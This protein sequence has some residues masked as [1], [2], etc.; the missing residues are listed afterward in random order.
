MHAVYS[1]VANT[2]PQLCSLLLLNNSSYT[3]EP[4]GG[5]EYLHFPPVQFPSPSFCWDQNFL[6]FS[7]SRCSPLKERTQHYSRGRSHTVGIKFSLQSFPQGEGE[8]PDT[9]PFSLFP[10][11]RK[12]LDASPASFPPPFEK[13]LDTSSLS[14]LYFLPLYTFPLIFPPP[15]RG[16]QFTLFPCSIPTPPTVKEEASVANWGDIFS[17]FQRPIEN[18]YNPLKS[19]QNI[20]AIYLLAYS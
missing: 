9:S 18:L 12:T 2:C 5:G 10:N 13:M 11:I 7:Q 8:E 19:W 16:K 20:R 4:Q 15:F 3:T 1:I 17:F 6:L 14:P